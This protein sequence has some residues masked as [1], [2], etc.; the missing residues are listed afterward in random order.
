VKAVSA[1]LRR[2]VYQVRHGDGT[3]PHTLIASDF[4]HALQQAATLAR[5]KRAPV[6]LFADG[7]FAAECPADA[8]I[9]LADLPPDLAEA[10]ASSGLDLV[11]WRRP[12]DGNREMVAS[13]LH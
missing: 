4:G 11:G 10:L 6:Q 5:M 13:G 9:L 3:E 1:D 7:A 2:V 12:D 8:A